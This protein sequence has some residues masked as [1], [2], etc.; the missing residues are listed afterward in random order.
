MAYSNLEK[1]YENWRYA[2]DIDWVGYI[3]RMSKMKSVGIW[4][5]ELAEN[6][7]KQS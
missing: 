3:N 2:L 5:K 6:I 1:G 7:L 4:V